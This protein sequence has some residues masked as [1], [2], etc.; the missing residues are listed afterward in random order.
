M[1]V[2]KVIR[3]KKSHFF[4]TYILKVLKQITSNGGITS[5]AKQ[6]LNSVL[7][8]ISKY[9]S[10]IVLDI[11]IIL[12]KKTI[13]EKEIVSALKLILTGE[14]LTNSLTEGSKAVENFKNFKETKNLED[15]EDLK[16]KQSKANILFP[17]SLVEKFLRRFGYTKIMVSSLAPVYLASVLEYL[18]FEILD[19]SNNNCIDDKRVRITIRDIELSIRTDPEIN[20][21]FTKMNINLL[22]GGVVPFIHPSLINKPNKTKLKRCVVSNRRFHSGTVAIRNIKKQQKFSD[23]LIFSRLSF[24]HFIRH[25]FSENKYDSKI[26]IG[27]DVF[28]VLQYFIEQ[29]IVDVLRNANYLA[30]HAGRVKLTPTDIGLISFLQNKSKNPYTDSSEDNVE[31]FSLQNESIA[32]ISVSSESN[33]SNSELM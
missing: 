27:K 17:P 15:N 28:V 5:N 11:T 23:S 13:S 29:Y 20:N 16:Y 26:K 4:E 10:N 2:S 19:M 1:D 18:T 12:K 32:E 31:L 6:Q 9:I 21:L 33:E 25:I 8:T 14:L 3:K 22:G 24:E 7:C 30:I